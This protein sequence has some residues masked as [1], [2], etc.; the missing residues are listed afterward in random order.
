[1]KKYLIIIILFSSQ[2]LFAQSKK[3]FSLETEKFEPELIQ[4]MRNKNNTGQAIADKFISDYAS[5]SANSKTLIIELLNNL[6]KTRLKKIEFYDQVLQSI[7][8]VDS[9]KK[10]NGSNS[11]T[12][13]SSYNKFISNN[14]NTTKQKE[15]FIEANYNVLAKSQ[16]NPKSRKIKWRTTGELVYD[17]KDII[18]YSIK[19][20]DLYCTS[21]SDS[22]S[23]SDVEASFIPSTQKIEVSNSK[24]YWNAQSFSK[25]SLY[26]IAKNISI[27]V[28]DKGYKVDSVILH[29]NYFFKHKILGSLE[30]RAETRNPKKKV[31]PVFKSYMNSI[32]FKNITPGVDFNGGILIK[33]NTFYGVGDNTRK[34]ILHC[35]KYDRDAFL[36]GS[37]SFIFTRDKI[38]SPETN[39]SIRILGDSIF[40]PDVSMS[41]NVVSAKLNVSKNGNKLSESPYSNSYNNIDMFLKSI[42]WTSGD[43]TVYFD[44]EA[45]VNIPFISN[46]YYEREIFKQFQGLNNVNPLVQLY[47]VYMYS[48]GYDG[49]SVEFISDQMGV[50]R[51][52]TIHLLMELAAMGYV[53][54][55]LDLNT[56]S[57]SE[58]FLNLVEAYKGNKDFDVIIFNTV[59]DKSTKGTISLDDGKASLL[60][61]DRITLSTKNKVYVFPSDTVVVNKNLNLKFNGEVNVGNYEFFGSDYSFDY[62]EFKV[63]MNG[64][65]QMQYYVPSWRRNEYGKLYPVKVINPIDSLRGELFIDFP[66]NK[67]GRLQYTDYPKF[68]N[69]RDAYVFYDLP[70]IKNGVYTKDQLYVKL[71]PFE[72]DSLTTISSRN[73]KFYGSIHSGGIFPDIDYF[74]K[75]QKDFSLGFLYDTEIEGLDLFNKGTYRD[76]LTLNLEGLNGRGRISYLSSEIESDNIEFY[77]DSLKSIAH[78]FKVDYTVNDTLNTPLGLAD[79][80]SVFW[81]PE[82]DSMTISMLE[83]PFIFYDGNV[84]LEG[85]LAF[86]GKELTGE[87]D[88][89]FETA[90]IKSGYY[91]FYGDSINSN[92]LDFKLRETLDSPSEVEINNSAGVVDMIKREG[93]FMLHDDSAYVSFITNKYIAYIDS[94][95]WKMDDKTIELTSTDENKTPW[96]VTVDP[97]QDSL[98]FQAAQASYD[99]VTDKLDISKLLGIEVADAF[100]Y[101]ENN[102]LEILDNGWMQGFENAKIKIGIGANEHTLENANIVVHSSKNY[103]GDAEYYYTDTD[104]IKH[105]ITLTSLYVDTLSGKSIGRGDI[106]ADEEFMLNPYFSFNGTVEVS[107]ASKYLRFQGY[108]GIQNYCDDI[109]AGEIPIEG[110]VDPNNVKVEITNF[111]ELPEYSFI[112]NGIYSADSTYSAAFLST[113]RDLID[114]DFISAKGSITYDEPEA[115]YA[116]GGDTI[117]GIMQDEVRFYNDECRL[118]AK[119]ELKLY[120]PDKVFEIKSYGNID[121]DMNAEIIQT[122]MVLGLNFEFNKII[123]D[124][125]RINLQEAS[126]KGVFEEESKIQ[127]LGFS[128]LMNK[129]YGGD[130]DGLGIFGKDLPKELQFGILLSDIEFFWDADQNLFLSGNEVGVHNFNGNLVNKIFN[131]KVE[132]KKRKGGDDITI[133]IVSQNGKY[134]YFSFRDNVLNFYTNNRDIMDKFD[135]IEDEDREKEVN[136]IKY[137]F[138]KASKLKVRSFQNKYI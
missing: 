125:I 107:G 103:S 39:I 42:S 104:S 69:T 18:K 60:E 77:T 33:K 47:D 109:D 56:V 11:T 25:D 29:D 129:P 114:Y 88:I 135:A 106:L 27:D 71:A 86:L 61:I 81:K 41:Y 36:F 51:Q 23:I 55:D 49:L 126:S 13:I 10:G 85:N 59:R 119:G 111:D 94:V 130:T 9:I 89:L 128:R 131:G 2:F 1:M 120:N 123:M 20:S 124:E 110:N 90:E 93:R 5:Y 58:K 95:V 38:F 112:Y 22:L 115:C 53:Y 65:Q 54:V 66:T 121:F 87:G 98:R 15:K 8:L 132:I 28:K 31:Y 74:V 100:V 64:N 7:I 105:P 83:K 44:T 12:W 138:K 99:L 50:P 82:A 48:D 68:N 122:Q 43:N 134:F 118:G 72:L 133:Y 3:Q 92:M 113:N 96:F 73:V 79:N 101:P 17:S 40:H 102:Q 116:I 63:V 80:V 14:S 75:V 32:Y 52:H 108:S 26:V 127:K 136:G 21:G 57:F 24:I 4:F 70:Q 45:H 19:G 35:K 16:L 67:S 37:K 62:D 97:T 91:N 117:N 78:S 76:E 137:R 6:R 84:S 46:H 34:A 30:G